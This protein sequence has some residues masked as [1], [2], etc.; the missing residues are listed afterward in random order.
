MKGS[1]YINKI[2]G[3]VPSI[4]YPTLILCLICIALHLFSTLFYIYGNCPK[5]FVILVNSLAAY[6]IFTPMH[7]ACH[8]SIASVGSGHHYLNDAI[9]FLSSALFPAPYYAFKFAHLKHHKYTN[10]P[11][12]D[13]D[14][15]VAQ[16]PWFLLP[17][18]WASIE[19]KYYALYIPI[20]FTRPLKEVVNSNIE[21]NFTLISWY[22]FL[23]LRRHPL[24]CN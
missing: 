24:Y 23:L 7:D 15:W 6:V 16:G 21:N 8:G 1:N 5:S 2:I 22:H 3:S 10:D 20:I 4:A 12:H 13:P 11:V 17:L 18:K 14:V 9:G 19:L